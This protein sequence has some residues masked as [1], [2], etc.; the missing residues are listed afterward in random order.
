MDFSYRLTGTGWAQARIADQMT[1]AEIP[2]SYL[3]DAFGDLL[4]AAAALKRGDSDVERFSWDGEPAESRWILERVGDDVVVKILRFDD[5]FKPQHD[6]AGRVVFE[7]RQ[8]LVEFVRAVTSAAAALLEEV[9]ED[10]YQEQWV[11]HAF[12]MAA[13]V[14]LSR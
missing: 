14:E 6:D 2:A 7:T 8:P 11:E 10:A 13:F 12:P 1:S 9:G 5:I 4:S 3:T